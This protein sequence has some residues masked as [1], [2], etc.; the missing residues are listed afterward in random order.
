MPSRLSEQVQPS[1]RLFGPRIDFADELP[2]NGRT[3][4]AEG[5]KYPLLDIIH[6][7]SQLCGF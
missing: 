5:E 7:V 4:C 6:H 2:K 1:L 3:N